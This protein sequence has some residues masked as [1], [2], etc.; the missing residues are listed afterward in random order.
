[1]KQS[2]KASGKLF[3]G[4]L[5]GFL[6]FTLTSHP[7]SIVHKKLPNKQVK[8]ISVFPHIKVHSK[9]RHLH[10]H[11]WFNFSILYAFLL[12]IKSIRKKNPFLH[13]LFLG[14]IVQ[15]LSYKDRFKFFHSTSENKK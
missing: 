10:L 6:F 14:S 12:A 2:I 1:M 15:G 7:K 8:R 3:L 5:A 13:G 9:D 11:H 4:G